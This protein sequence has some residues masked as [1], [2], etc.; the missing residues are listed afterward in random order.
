MN[1]LILTGAT[2]FL[3]KNILSVLN[4][5]NFEV[6][7]LGNPTTNIVC[8]ISIEIPKF[9]HSFDLVV[10]AA[11]KAHSVPKNKSEEKVFFDVNL[12]GTHNLLKG[13]E[14][15]NMLPKAF[16]FISSV[17]VYGCESGTMINENHPLN[18]K[19]AYGLSKIQAE[20]LIQNWC[21]KNNV[22]C[23]ILRLPLLVGKNPPGNLGAMIRGIEKGYYFNIGG[24]KAKKS[25]VFA[26]D[27]AKI[28]PDAS[29]SGGIYNLTDGYHP[30][31]AELASTI[32][33]TINKKRIF[34]LPLWVANI[35]ARL[36]DLLGN[37]SP[38]NS[39]K[40]AKI[41]ADLTF[42]DTKAKKELNWKPSPVL[43][44]FKIK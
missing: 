5:S 12:N 16:V 15:S 36:G 21:A 44:G 2:G 4:K 32:A 27:V 28:I 29:K 43:Q 18:A 22:I 13:F 17:A 7:T 10:H 1:K 42:D 26:K 35:M 8:D 14:N 20:Q 40:L 25:M 3:G 11:G 19:D 41:M 6:T 24:G 39:R 31:F 9:P 34:N 23:T 30:S 38:I 37:K 33:K